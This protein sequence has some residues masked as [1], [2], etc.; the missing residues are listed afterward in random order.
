MKFISSLALI[1]LSVALVGCDDKPQPAS[2]N[3]QPS[4]QTQEAAKAQ[5]PAEQQAVTKTV[6][7]ACGVDSN[8]PVIVTYRFEGPDAVSA[9]VA[10]KGQ[11][12]SASGFMR[13]MDD[14]ESARFTSAD[15]FVWVAD[16]LT[17]D[18][19]DKVSGNMLYIDG[20]ESDEILVK[21]CSTPKSVK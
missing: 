1:G 12:V 15:K 14:K 21:Y 9:E 5:A 8:E 7:Y 4:A 6:E 11:S 13:D 17:L 16:N 19:L 2:T 20:K 10:Y 18:N 3:A